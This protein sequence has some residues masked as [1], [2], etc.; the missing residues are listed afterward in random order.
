MYLMNSPQNLPPMHPS[1]T[2]SPPRIRAY[3]CSSATQEQASPLLLPAC[4]SAQSTV[5]SKMRP[6]PYRFFFDAQ[7]LREPLHECIDTKSVGLVRPFQQRILIILDSLDE[8]GVSRANDL[9]AQTHCYVDANPKSTAVVTTKPLPGLRLIDYHIR[10]PVLSDEGALSLISRIAG[11][12]VTLGEMYGWPESMR[13]AAKRPLFAVMIG[14]ELRRRPELHTTRPVQLIDRLAQQVVDEQPP[15]R[16]KTR[17]PVAGT[18]RSGHQHRAAC[19]YASFQCPCTRTTGDS[20]IP[21]SSMNT[22]I[23]SISRFR[24]CGIGMRPERSSKALHRYTRSSRHLI[25]G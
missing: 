1:E 13:N 25:A 14:A 22:T 10:M 20:P 9:L 24:F 12:H 23:L 15:R 17:H 3:R 7:E 2:F 5:H 11:R 6:N 4:F 8:V 18:R 16:S 21:L 19:A